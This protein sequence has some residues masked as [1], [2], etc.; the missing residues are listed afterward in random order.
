MAHPDWS[1]LRVIGETISH[2]RV[3]RK[4]GGGGMGVV[5]EVED[6]KLHRHVALKF[7]PEDLA[8][9]LTALRRFEREA[10]A[11]SAL[12]H[13]NICTIYDVETTNGQPFIAMELLE[14]QTLKHTI[15]SKPVELDLL[16]DLAIQIADALDAAH[17]A[18]IIHRDIKPANIFV[19]K[20]GQAKVLDFGLAKMSAAKAAAAADEMATALTLPGD[21]IGTLLYMSPEQVRGK[22]LDARTDLFSFG[23]VMYEMATGTLPFRGETS[24]SVSHAILSDSPTPLAR[25]NR[26]VPPKLEEIIGKC[27]EKD[28]D[29]RYQHALELRADLLRLKRDS[30]TG[31]ISTASPAARPAKKVL[32]G[33]GVA[34]LLIALFA[35]IVWS[36]RPP[37]L[38]DRSE[39]V[40][41]TDFTDSAVSP[42]LSPDGRMVTFLRGPETFTTE[43]EVFVKLLPDGEPTQLTHNRKIKMSPE[44]SPDGSRIAYT[45][46]PWDTWIV[47]VLGGEPHLLLPNA[48][49]LTWLG[50]N[51]MLYS[52]IESGIHMGIVTSGDNRSG[53]QRVYFPS[54]PVSM[55]HRSYASPDRKWVI[56]VEME[57]GKWVPCRLVPLDGSSTGGRIGPL[58]GACT[59][60]AWSPD[61][62]WMYF[63]S[64][65]SG[66]FHTWRQRFPA[67]Q[68]EQITS[69]PTEEEGIAMAPDGKS[70]I[71]AIGIQRTSLWLRKGDQERQITFEGNASIG[72]CGAFSPGGKYFYFLMSSTANVASGGHVWRADVESG[73]TEAVLTDYEVLQFAVMSN[74]KEIAF[75]TGASG[76]ELWVASTQGRFAPRKLGENARRI[77]PGPGGVWYSVEQ[78]GKR[79]VY[80]LP[81]DGTPPQKV[82]EGVV[83]ESVSPDG[84]RL[85]VGRD[86][87]DEEKDTV[88]EAVRI[89][90]PS[91]PVPICRNC[92]AQWSG[93]GRS[94][95]LSIGQN[96]SGYARREHASII[97]VLL[98][99][100]TG[101]PRVDHV[102]R[103]EAE[104]LKLPGARVVGP[105]GAVISADGSVIAFTRSTANRNLFSVPVH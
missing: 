36:R 67:G 74:D 68:P 65:A 92:W 98:D 39:W 93:D 97:A 57:Y 11:A 24:G 1:R 62:S 22:E 64:N 37:R 90:D 33:V 79:A 47:P 51:R 73:R 88:V 102:I 85:L 41:L 91:K 80:R 53:A 2:Y 84:T 25:L 60:A 34:V 86:S 8:P 54:D 16:L 66:T 103:E 44:F 52:E 15:D 32:A 10:Q 99:P 70:F 61:G 20:R 27:L 87:S 28:R 9:D 23:V 101:L 50:K 81:T 104:F 30:Q 7:L 26:R 76:S 12:N 42:S 29:L 72:N 14:G 94:V 55:E 43:G 35:A 78:N 3:L 75:A 69:G 21:A 38:A 17:A 105:L 77:R 5:Y 48:S 63:T 19:T 6:L 83:L 96:T 95:Y 18:G 45:Q 58:K 100:Q 13:P 59:A 46:E 56:V 49:G 82:M 31:A 71:T 89:A 40:Q 4:L